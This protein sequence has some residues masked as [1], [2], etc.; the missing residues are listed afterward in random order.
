MFQADEEDLPELPI[1][2]EIEETSNSSN[3]EPNDGNT[4]QDKNF[5]CPDCSMIFS[6]SQLLRSHARN[7]HKPPEDTLLFCPVCKTAV[8]HGLENL[9]MHLYES[10]GIGEVFRCEECNFK[11]TIKSNYS[12]HL[13]TTHSE[14]HSPKKLRMCNK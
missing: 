12:K 4:S 2:L 10:H 13:N 11:T 8:L 1:V 3:G 6:S 7:T 9:K 14:E 5:K